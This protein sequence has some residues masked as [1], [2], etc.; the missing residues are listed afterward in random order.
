MD[1]YR[2]GSYDIVITDINMPVMSGVKLSREIK[3][4]NKKQVIIVISAH[5]EA[6]YLLDLINMGVDNFVL[7]P[8]DIGQFLGVLHKAISLVRFS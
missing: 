1:K 2:E 3:A 4:S 8:L 5:D 6:K 7:K